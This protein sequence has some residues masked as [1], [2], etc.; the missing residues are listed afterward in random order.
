M[1][2]R[3]KNMDKWTVYISIKKTPSNVVISMGWGKKSAKKI[4]WNLLGTIKREEVKK[5]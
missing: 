4:V 2:Y 3:L 5:K 1:D